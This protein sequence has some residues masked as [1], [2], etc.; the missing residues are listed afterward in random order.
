MQNWF[1]CKEVS[2]PEYKNIIIVSSAYDLE[3]LSGP[4]AF[5]DIQKPID[6]SDMFIIWVGQFQKGKYIVTSFDGEGCHELS[7]TP[8]IWRFIPKNPLIFYDY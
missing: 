4:E 6:L 2:P 3:E 7:L 1:L 8:I 5:E